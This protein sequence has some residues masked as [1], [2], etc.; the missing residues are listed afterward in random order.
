MSGCSAPGVGIRSLAP[1]AILSDP[2]ISEASGIV[3][4]RQH[5]NVFWVHNDSGDG[6][7]LF[8]VNSAGNR[9][10]EVMIANALNEDWEDIA[11]DDRQH[12]YIGDIGNNANNRRDLSVYIIPEPDTV[13]DTV[14]RVTG[15]LSFLYPD[16][17]WTKTSPRN[18][19]AEALFYYDHTLWIL[20]KHRSDSNTKLYRFPSLDTSSVQTLEWVDRFAIEGMVT[21]ADVRPDGNMLAVLT[22]SN[23]WIFDLTHREGNQLLTTPV[24]QIPIFLY[25]AEG[26]C[27]QNGDLVIVNEQREWYRI[28]SPVKNVSAPKG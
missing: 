25:Q 6:P 1:S 26:I 12:L 17:D 27:W 5:K 4:S 10:A 18:F 22:Y 24:K 20:T 7:R 11:L 23:V 13:K 3:A 14:V 16:Q 19:D 21:G 28:P 9:L 8:A 15:K 2:D